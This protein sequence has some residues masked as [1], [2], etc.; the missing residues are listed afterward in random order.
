MPTPT[1]RREGVVRSVSFPQI[2]QPPPAEHHHDPLHLFGS[3]IVPIED[4]TVSVM[5]SALNYGT[6]VLGGIRGCWNEEEGPR[7]ACRPLDHPGRLRA[8][9]FDIVARTVEKY[10]GWLAPVY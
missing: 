6:A 10:R 4:A 8:R 7:Y 9:F 3:R 1:T 5:T 2:A